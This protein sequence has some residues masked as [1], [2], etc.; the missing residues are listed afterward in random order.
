MWT[1]MIAA[2]LALA[3]EPVRDQI[4]TTL[5]EVD[6]VTPEA[7]VVQAARP[8]VVFIETEITQPVRSFWGSSNRTFSGSGSGVVIHSDGYIVTNYH[9]V[10]GANT[11]TVSFDGDPQRYGAELVSFVRSEDLALLKM[12]PPDRRSGEASVPPV[13]MGTSVDLMEGERV[14]AIGSPYGQTHTVS[15]GIISGLHRDVNVPNE[16]LHFRD[17]IQTD[18]SINFGNSGG[19][20][21]N[22]RGEL[23]GI[24]T[25]M[26]RQAENIGFAIPVD[27]VREVLTDLLFPQARRSWLGFELAPGE[28]LRVARVWPDGP[29]DGAGLCEGD[30]VVSIQ[31]KDILT[32]EDFLHAS[33]EIEPEATVQLEVAGTGERRSLEVS[34]W[35]KVDGLLFERLGMTVRETLIGS[36]RWIL[37]DRVGPDGPAEDLGLRNGDLIPAILPRA[38]GAQSALRIRDRSTLA[39]VISRLQPGVSIDMDVYRDEDEDREFSRDE[40]YKGTLELR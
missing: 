15:T 18:A 33:L 4:Y 19:P 31:G 40:L 37:V 29:A 32:H 6:R 26:N 39:Q 30:F 34:T 23:I 20:L 13:R 25:A 21:L 5:A 3:Q 1:L 28:P 8:S 22:I 14:V 2:P 24:N 27:R 11:I 9:V 12:S 17:L 7:L 10:K 35:D 36:N 16:G 38:G